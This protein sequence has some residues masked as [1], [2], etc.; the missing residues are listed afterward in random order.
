MGNDLPA[1]VIP[2]LSGQHAGI[3]PLTVMMHLFVI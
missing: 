3:L 1:Y 2:L